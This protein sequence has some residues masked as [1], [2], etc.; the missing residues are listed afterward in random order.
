MKIVHS[1]HS[2]V[3]SRICGQGLDGVEAP[4]SP[5]F[6]SGFLFNMPVENNCRKMKPA[7]ITLT[8]LSGG[9]MFYVCGRTS[10][11]RNGEPRSLART[12]SRMRSRHRPKCVLP[13]NIKDR[14]YKPEGRAPDSG[15]LLQCIEDGLEPMIRCDGMPSGAE[16][17]TLPSIPQDRVVVPAERDPAFRFSQTEESNDLGGGLYDACII[18]WRHGSRIALVLPIRKAEPVA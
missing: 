8:F 17:P 10:W 14:W 4:F 2:L 11:P 13:A 16:Q 7:S 15:H 9:S 1:H 12:G 6:V 3:I 18:W 5:V